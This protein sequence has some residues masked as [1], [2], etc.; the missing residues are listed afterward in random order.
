MKIARPV[1]V[2]AGVALVGVGLLTALL[3]NADVPAPAASAG[4]PAGRASS[5]DDAVQR[6]LRE[7]KPTV[8]EFGANA[9]AACREMKP[10][11]QALR[12]EHGER[13]AVV[14]VD[15]IAQREHNYIQRYGIQLMP[16]QIFFDAQGREIGR[17]LGK[18]SGEQILA[19]LRVTDTPAA[20]ELP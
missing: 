14:D 16:T 5:A 15:L 20:G 17:N 12:R 19:R 18:L 10:V 4:A 7:G 11:L 2:T 3:L 1:A 13:I 8:A 6:V 9:C